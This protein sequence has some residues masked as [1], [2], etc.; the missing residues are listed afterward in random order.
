MAPYWLFFF[1]IWSHSSHYGGGFIYLL[2]LIPHTTGSLRW[3]IWLIALRL[4]SI[5]IPCT[6]IVRSKVVICLFAWNLSII[7]QLMLLPRIW[8]RGFNFLVVKLLSV[9]GCSDKTCQAKDI[10]VLSFHCLISF[11]L[12]LTPTILNRK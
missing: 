12:S 5:I 4:Q 3:R 6:N 7:M 2:L 1:K 8:L 9:M 11:H 10:Y